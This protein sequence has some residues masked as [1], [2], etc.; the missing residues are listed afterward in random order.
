MNMIYL[1]RLTIENVLHNKMYVELFDVLKEHIKN[2]DYE[3]SLKC[4]LL[5]SNAG[6]K[7]TF[8]IRMYKFNEICDNKCVYKT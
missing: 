4:N 6:N 3:H 1:L 5:A 8:M 7:V 2:S